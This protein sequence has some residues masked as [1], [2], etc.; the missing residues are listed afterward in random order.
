MHKFQTTA[1]KFLK[2]KSGTNNFR[3]RE[4]VESESYDR[5]SRT[6]LTEQNIATIR[7]VIANYRRFRE[8]TSRIGMRVL[9]PLL[10][11]S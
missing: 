3:E 6:S 11:I 7:G 4:A 9:K 2:C 1:F 8:I 10:L 5:C